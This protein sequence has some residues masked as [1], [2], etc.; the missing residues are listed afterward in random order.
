MA[1]LNE[2]QLLLLDNMM[3]YRGAA[4]GRSVEDIAAQMVEDARAGKMEMFS[5]GF[6]SDAERAAEIG[7]AILADPQLCD[8]VRRDSIDTA[9][10]RASCFVDSSG[11][12]TVAIKGTGG[13]YEAWSDN[14]QGAYQSDTTSQKE[15]A[16]FVKAQ[17][18]HYSDIT[19]T[20]HSKGGNLAQYATVVC[21]DSID[22]C[23]SFD[24]QGFG[25]EFLRKYKAQIDA[26]S[27]KIKSVCA[28]GDF[29][30]ILLFS[31]AGETVYLNTAD[32]KGY[33]DNH[34]SYT[35]WKGNSGK[36]QN[37]AFC[38]TVAQSALSKALD[39]ALDGLVAGVDMTN[40]IIEMA[41][42]NVIGG[43]IAG[44]MSK[45]IS[46]EDLLWHIKDI[47]QDE[48][49]IKT[50]IKSWGKPGVIWNPLEFYTYVDNILSELNRSGSS[51]TMA[52]KYVFSVDTEAIGRSAESLSQCI[53]RLVKIENMINE[54]HLK[55]ELGVL[56]GLKLNSYRRGIE[57][58][59][60][61][62][63][64]LLSSLEDIRSVYSDTE[65]RNMQIKI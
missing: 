60:N 1:E 4:D 12:A 16:E 56:Y 3:Y 17:S 5:G 55:G 25:D 35:L 43:G 48:G 29:V 42:I 51:N 50:L 9:M 45:G 7:E 15:L 59:S 2:E 37:G 36:M 38:E 41:I 62:M 22:R 54:I 21:G 40:P 14:F 32:K 39:C 58:E 31:I 57:K 23:V 47:L 63:R 6:E 61:K 24:G 30:N 65:N 19:I 64:K 27:G 13:T 44:L 34:S 53:S 26:N 33:P 52:G 49:S 18:S 10:V 8:L 11:E 20:G 28:E 46:L